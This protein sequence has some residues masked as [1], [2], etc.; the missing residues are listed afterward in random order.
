MQA[1]K[2]DYT[3]TVMIRDC[4]EKGRLDRDPIPYTILI[5]VALN[6]GGAT[7]STTTLEKGRL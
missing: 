6:I 1:T 7:N 3:M 5:L 4:K 2:Q